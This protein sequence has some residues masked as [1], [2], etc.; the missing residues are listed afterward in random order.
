MRETGATHADLVR[1]TRKSSSAVTQIREG[2][3][4]SLKLDTAAALEREYGYRAEWLAYGKLPKRVGAHVERDPTY[5]RHVADVAAEL[6]D[7]RE[8]PPPVSLAKFLQFVDFFVEALPEEPDDEKMR[9]TV[10]RHLRLVA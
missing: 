2:P 8:I 9:T 3:T 7:R 6:V 5:W 4:K 1:V 10:R